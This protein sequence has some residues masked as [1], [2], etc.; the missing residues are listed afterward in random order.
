MI[1]VELILQLTIFHL[2]RECLSL[3]LQIHFTTILDPDPSP[4]T[5]TSIYTPPSTLQFPYHLFAKVSL[6]NLNILF[7]FWNGFCLLEISTTFHYTIS[8]III[9]G[10]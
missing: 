1:S 6:T 5:P 2:H 8:L 9:T 4:S 10:H 3:S 7:T